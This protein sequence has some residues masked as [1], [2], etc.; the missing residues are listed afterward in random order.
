MSFFLDGCI[1]G[2]IISYQVLVRVKPGCRTYR[3]AIACFG[4]IF[5]VTLPFSSEEIRQSESHIGVTIHNT[6]VCLTGKYEYLLCYL[7]RAHLEFLKFLASLSYFP[8]TS[9]N[10]VQFMLSMSKSSSAT[11]LL[12]ESG[13]RR[14]RKGTH[15][16]SQCNLDLLP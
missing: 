6:E 5:L 4:G 11:G 7:F 14:M 3:S 12:K 9:L 8:R 13:T 10:L 1:R 15:S 2:V 16:C